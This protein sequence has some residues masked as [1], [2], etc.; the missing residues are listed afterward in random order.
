MYLVFYLLGMTIMGAALVGLA[1]FMVY[2]SKEKVSP[3]YHILTLVIGIVAL[4]TLGYSWIQFMVG[5]YEPGYDELLM[6]LLGIGEGYEEHI[7]FT[8]FSKDIN[9]TIVKATIST[10]MATGTLLGIFKGIHGYLRK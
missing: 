5:Y 6:K 4:L 9:Y 3:V 2:L 8:I 10:Y 7:W 1:L